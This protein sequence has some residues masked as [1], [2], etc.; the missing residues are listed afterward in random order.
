MR[1]SGKAPASS[2]GIPR[3][4]GGIPKTY[5]GTWEG[6]RMKFAELVDLAELT[7]LCESFTAATGAATALLELDGTVLIATGWQDI[8]TRFHRVNPDSA[9]RCRESD[10]DL[11]GRLKKG[12]PY[13]LYQCKNGLV[14]VAVP[15]LAGG[16]HV[17]NFFAGQFFLSP[18]DR[19]FFI[20]QA[21]QFGF[22]QD[23][24][25]EALGRV[26]V[27]DEKH[28]RNLLGFFSRLARIF[29]EMGMARIQLEETNRQLTVKHAELEEEIARREHADEA[30]RR[31]ESRFLGIAG[32]IPGVVYQFYAKPDG[33]RGFSYVSE[34]SL[35]I[36]GIPNDPGPFMERM[37]DRVHPGD[38]QRF[39]DSIDAA[40][41]A[42][43]RWEFEGR[44]IRPDGN[45]MYFRG[46]SDPVRE[47][48]EL[49]FSGMLL[50]ITKRKLAETALQDSEEQLRTIIE[51]APFSIQ[52]M[53]TEGR[54]ILINR[55]FE[56][57]WGL[58]LEDLRDYRILSDEQ[59]VRHGIMPII[60][61]GFA[62]EV[63]EIPATHYDSM[64]TSGKGNRPWVRS[65][66]YP[67]RDTKGA[68]RNIILI[69][70]DIT[71]Q[72]EA[73]EAL[74]ES[75]SRHRR[76]VET[77]N[78]GIWSMDA[79]HVTT[80]VNQKMAD[81][82]GY[83]VEEIVGRAISDF[84]FSE[85]LPH[86]T[87]QME[88]RHQGHS[89][90]YE[91]R[92]HTGDGGI[93]WMKVS[94]TAIF[95]DAG[96]FAGSFAML[97]DITDRKLAEEA[98]LRKNEELAA[99]TEEMTAI[100]EELRQNY[101]ELKRIQDAL[102]L[103]RRKLNLL[104]QVTF[105]ELQSGIFSLSAYLELSGTRG[106]EEKKAGYISKQKAILKDM[107]KNL[108][109]A[110]NYQG[111]GMVPPKWQNVNQV[112]LFA[113]S[114]MDTLCLVRDVEL[115]SLEIYADPL[116]ERVFGVLVE[117]VLKWGSGA[118]TIR[119]HYREEKG[120]L[121]LTFE[122]NGQGI[123]DGRKECI[124]ERESR[125]DG[126]LGLYLVREILSITRITIRETGEPGAGARFEI[127]VPEGEYRF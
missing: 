63:V 11:A 25:L 83:P 74:R 35:E 36:L 6:Y 29:A 2:S 40:V 73:V 52:V 15:I 58:T 51:E 66:I 79:R 18:P 87:R 72:V 118:T 3:V 67:T 120:R 85:D 75:E 65:R 68:I 12:E 116:L 49:V 26:P 59:L 45:V 4:A 100:D 109:F 43:S 82:L 127:S 54:I 97:F 19:E 117:N 122:D 24:Y 92:I 30:L 112:F 115:G 10:T 48:E 47:K 41:Q 27:Y 38:R 88:L 94:A 101:E 13:N 76:I 84:I 107:T 22:D 50:D 111:L 123:P 103:A 81:M 95:D 89:S 110:R 77:A 56:K 9:A 60:E 55:A 78:E 106:S 21:D 108:S 31:S 16:N 20:H 114:H 39:F 34:R 71:S 93:R 46:I 44:I 80:F 99:A 90:V 61:R 7:E 62:G 1:I 23:A 125:Q 102:G 86:N 91:G 96:K 124:F 119:L 37:I 105:E 64:Q 57:L 104:N 53:N 5:A 33:Q 42:V 28:V 126:G 98:L 70:E 113:I 17:A 14:D 8:C 121:L 32:T 69:H